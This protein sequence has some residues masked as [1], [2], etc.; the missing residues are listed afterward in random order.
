MV[1]S[2]S[3]LRRHISL[4]TDQLLSEGEKILIVDDDPS[5]RGP[6]RIFLESQ[7]LQV[8]EAGSAQE[9]LQA[10]KEERVGMILLDIG[11]PDI[12]GRTLLPQLVESY[13]DV[14]IIM[15]TG[16]ADLQVALDCIRE[17]ADD[18]LSKPSQFS[19]ILFVVKKTLEK[20]RLIFENRKYQEDLEKAHFRIHV[21]HQL[22]IKMNTAYLST[23]ELDDIL[24]AVMV[25]ITAKEGLRFNRAF[26]AMFDDD[27]KYLVGRLAIG[28]GCRDEA[29]RIWSD[30]QGKQL[31]FMELVHGF[32]ERCKGP[33]NE[34][35]RITANLKISVEDHNNILIKAAKERRSI[36]V[37]KENGSVPLPLERRAGM[38]EG[39]GRSWPESI[40]RRQPI[41][42]APLVVP[43]DLIQLLNE[44][45]FVVVPLYS[46]SRSLGVIVADNSITGQ[47]ITD[48]HINSLELF[49]SQASLAI[50]HSHLYVDQQMKITELEDL[51][52]ELEKNKDLLVEAERY[53]ALGQ[54]AAQLVHSI[55]NPITSI[56]GVARILTRKIDSD[57]HKKFLDVI[58]K[59]TARLEK[60]L[61]D[62]YSFTELN[63]EQREPIF[64]HA[65]LRR[66]LMLVQQD[67]VRQGIEW[68]LNFSDEKVQILA[69]L[70]QI[71]Q[72]FLH[73]VKNGIE[74]MP[75]GGRLDINVAIKDHWLLVAVR[76][77][78]IGMNDDY[79][80][81]AFDPFF[82]TKTYG[83]GMGLTMVE[84]V[85]NSHGG[86]LEMK[87]RPEGGMEAMVNLPVS[88]L[89]ESQGA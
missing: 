67:M 49:S 1:D 43:T 34:V 31:S 73:L 2:I 60:I 40:E 74:A 11:L 69:N 89:I 76:D 61:D 32:R 63:E 7:G 65:M 72:M 21:L 18:F 66:T 85:L 77:T 44:E 48:N 53:S 12:D 68:G 55:R 29:G 5:I 83:T 37:S 62:L 79:F 41:D 6:L 45:S 33:D 38:E 22:S 13:P 78:G 81:K 16:M 58:S 17:G 24:Q 27:N 23:V 26:L 10:L 54:M 20:R 70:K 59:E 8:G 56:G 9:L 82:T 30:I 3:G 39:G 80:D 15:L 71:R 46:P 25:G 14:A 35:N 51:T 84:N 86:T 19:E 57:E 42:E 28:P 47:P 36:R 64:L 52:E 4:A 75:N 50:E 87:R 88:L